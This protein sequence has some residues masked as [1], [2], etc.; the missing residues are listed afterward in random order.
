MFSLIILLKMLA[1]AK[2]VV[3]LVALSASSVAASDIAAAGRG[4]VLRASRGSDARTG[5]ADLTQVGSALQLRGGGSTLSHSSKVHPP[6]Q[7]PTKA[8]PARA[9]ARHSTR[10]NGTLRKHS[11]ASPETEAAA[12]AGGAAATG[13]VAA[14]GATAAAAGGGAASAEA[15]V[16]AAVAEVDEL[17]A[18]RALLQTR[19]QELQAAARGVSSIRR[20][21]A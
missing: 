20:G 6:V 10:G 18:E 14:G 12:A 8:A 4:S 11:A 13:S 5:V 21:P 2:T 19:L 9:E 15:A 7:Q 16:G 3:A 17:L 1:V